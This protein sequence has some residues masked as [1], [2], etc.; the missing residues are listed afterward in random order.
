MSWNRPTLC[1][2]LISSFLGLTACHNNAH[3]RTQK[4]IE[5]GE[6]VYSVSGIVAFGGESDYETG[7]SGFR[8]EV[9]MLS[10][11]EDGEAGPYLGLGVV[12]SGGFDFIA[13]YEYKRYSKYGKVTKLGKLG[14][15]AELNYTSGDDDTY[16]F[17]GGTVLHLRPS[18]T[19]TTAKGEPLYAG[20]HGLLALGSLKEWG[21]WNYSIYD[22]NTGYY[23]WNY[24]KGLVDYQFTS[25]GAGLTA[26]AEII[27]QSSS[28]QFQ[29]DAGL[30]KNSF[31]NFSPEEYE[32]QYGEEPSQTTF[33]ITGSAGMNFFKPAPKTKLP[34]APYPVPYYYEEE[35]TYEQ[36][37]EPEPVL[38]FDPETGL[39]IEKEPE[40]QF[41]PE[42]GEPIELEENIKF[43]PETG[44]PIPA[45]DKLEYDP[46]TGELIVPGLQKPVLEKVLLGGM[47]ADLRLVDG[48]SIADAT[49]WSLQGYMV[50]V[51]YDQPNLL[52]P[53]ASLIR[54][55][56]MNREINLS[57]IS[58]ITVVGGT[59]GI[60]GAL[61]GCIGGG[62]MG[63]GLPFLL[64][65]VTERFEMII[66]GL[67]GGPLGMLTGA[68]S[69][70]KKTAT[71]TYDLS[72][73]NREA[74]RSMIITLS[75]RTLG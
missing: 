35:E 43:D 67:I 70:Y 22:P 30:V 74:K 38:K 50:M 36:E 39:P 42:T 20:V 46:E 14:V 57:Q 55:R 66:I 64:G 37:A 31:S 62:I 60:A 71:E 45:E 63:F 5:P 72:T 19:S 16:G 33:I 13:G 32:S 56:R 54:N 26:G 3:L 75:K 73:M 44:E 65:M 53:N 69:G 68:T 28:L 15:Q 49:L 17:Q 10:G 1:L 18:Y 7:I 40:L 4:I 24:G 21:N 29:L 34:T 58:S 6:K 27:L 2:S 41:D 9:S 25:I 23:E 61:L 59:K 11:R 48:I 52:Y 12:E 47:K 8:G 51:N